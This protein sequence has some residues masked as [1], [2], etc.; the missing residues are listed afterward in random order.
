VYRA[1]P[2]VRDSVLAG[3]CWVDPQDHGL[4]VRRTLDAALST[5]RETVAERNFA[6]LESEAV[7]RTGER[8]VW[9]RIAEALQGR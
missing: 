7:R 6:W 3:A 1:H 5:D 8:A 9:T 4:D 2:T